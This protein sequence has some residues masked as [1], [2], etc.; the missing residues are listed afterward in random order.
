MKEKEFWLAVRQGLLLIVDA[1]E[2]RL[3]VPRTAVL[4]KDW[5]ESEMGGR[6]DEEGKG[7]D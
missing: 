1:I 5:K 6:S 2:R 3:G 7:G 4:R